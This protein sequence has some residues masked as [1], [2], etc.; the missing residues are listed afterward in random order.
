MKNLST[1]L[2]ASA[3]AMLFL[4]AVSLNAEEWAQTKYDPTGTWDYEV[5]TPDGNVTGEMIVAME[6]GE[7]SVTIKSDIYG[8]M[9]LE[10]ITFEKNVME[11]TISVEGQSMEMELK[12]DGDEMEGAVYTG[13]DELAITAERQKKN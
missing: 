12:F 9:T 3:V 11:G 5:E 10:D 13:E 6:D 2:K 8:D 7:Y 1:I 4:V